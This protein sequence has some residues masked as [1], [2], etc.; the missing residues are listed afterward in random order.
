MRSDGPRYLPTEFIHEIDTIA[1]TDPRESDWAWKLARLVE[2]A[3]ADGYR[4]G[5]M[6][7]NQEG[8]KAARKT[9]DARPATPPGAAETGSGGG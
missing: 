9:Y 2:D 6:R 3:F 4:Q 5:H 7:G 8:W 1:E